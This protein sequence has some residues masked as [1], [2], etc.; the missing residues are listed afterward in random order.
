MFYVMG[1]LM[2]GSSYDDEESNHLVNYLGNACKL[3]DQNYCNLV[4]HNGK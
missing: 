1:I 2:D 3:D 4:D